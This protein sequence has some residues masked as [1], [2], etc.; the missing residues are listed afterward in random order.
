MIKFKYKTNIFIKRFYLLHVVANYLQRFKYAQ[1]INSDSL[2]PAKLENR[3][4]V[5]RES[6]SLQNKN[7]FTGFSFKHTIAN[8]F[9]GYFALV[10]ATGIVSIA[11]YLLKMHQIAFLLLWLNIAFYS[12]LMLLLLVR[13]IYYFP[14]IK[15]DLF[16][17]QRG[18]GFFTLI[19]GTCVLGSQ[20]TILLKNAVIAKLFLA[21][22][23]IFWLVIIY[24]FFMAITIKRIKPPIEKGISG[25]WLIATVATQSLAILST[26]TTPFVSSPIVK[27]LLLF[28]AL[29]GYLTGCILYIVIISL[30]IYRF[31]FF[32]LSPNELSAPYWI[33]MGAVAI[34]TLAGSILVLNTKQWFFLEDINGF[35]KGFTLFFWCAGTWWIPLLVLLGV[36]KHLTKKIPFPW[37]QKG[38]HPSYWGMVFPLGMYTACTFKLSEAIEIDF[39]MFIPKYFI[40][41]GFAGWLMVFIGLVHDFFGNLFFNRH[42]T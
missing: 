33:N 11:S 24:T 37:T 19:A 8:L 27:E 38:Y 6:N 13:T 3:M 4:N 22:G 18:P 40:F 35:L 20:I 21:A 36:W 25:T 28:F 9:P 14:R 15:E 31:S 30:I 41:L 32:S 12:I 2:P 5:E 7:H 42:K 17:H 10:M 23:V 26:L 29:G 1:A 39:L 16:S 34:T